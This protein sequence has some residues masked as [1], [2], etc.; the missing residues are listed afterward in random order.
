[1]RRLAAT[2]LAVLLGGL[3]LANPA[4]GQTGPRPSGDA[5]LL[6]ADNAV[7]GWKRAD[8]PRVFARADL[9]GYIDGGAELFLE[10]GFDQLTLQKYRNGA[11]DVAVEVYRMVDPVAATGLYLMRKGKETRDPG[12]A[13][14]HTA[15][16]HQCLFTR[17]WFYV[18]VSSLS[19]ADALQH[20]LVAMAAEVAA[21]LPA[22]HVP[23]DLGRLPAKGLLAGSE[24]LVRG[25]YG[26]QALY[27]LGDDD[28]L[29]MGGRVTG[30]AANYAD[31]PG[32]AFTLLLVSY[33]DAAA[34]GRAFANLRQH[35]DKYL[36]PVTSGPAR[37]VFSDYEHKFGVAALSGRQ[38]EVRVHLVRQP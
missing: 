31:P 30:V 19:G 37:L 11:R 22:D 25:P 32:T 21:K 35:L 18:S 29:L 26:L 13:A 24:R 3:W 10:F 38:I 16:P 17:D 15:N 14:R 7:P 20:D 2:A 12:F 9:Y 28:I 23:A 27:T 4:A 36:T 1:M 34:A 5:A 33:P 8:A 6:P